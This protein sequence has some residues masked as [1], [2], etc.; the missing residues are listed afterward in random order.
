MRCRL[1][2]TRKICTNAKALIRN[3]FCCANVMIE[4]E[5][6]MIVGYARV[7]TNGQTLDAQQAAL[8]RDTRG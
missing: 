6:G 1:C 3:A 7:L 5:R 2:I 8:A 4:M